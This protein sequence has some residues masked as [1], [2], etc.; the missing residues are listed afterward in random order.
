MK[1]YPKNHQNE[2]YFTQYHKK[3]HALW[4]ETRVSTSY[5]NQNF[6]QYPPTGKKSLVAICQDKAHFLAY[7]LRAINIV[8]KIATCLLSLQ[9]IRI[10]RK[11]SYSQ[12]ILKTRIPSYNEF[13]R[14][15][16]LIMNGENLPKIR[17]ESNL[18]RKSIRIREARY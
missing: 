14:L 3:Q 9:R 10:R 11:N 16:N 1:I 15:T 7:F 8:M 12:V 5:L 18:Y 2:S 4:F 6:F 13:S 17:L